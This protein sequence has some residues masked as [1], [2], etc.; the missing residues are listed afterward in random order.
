MFIKPIDFSKYS[1]IKIGPVVNVLMIEKGDEFPADRFLV[2]GANNLLISPTPPPLMMLSKDFDYCLIDGDTLEIG[3]ATPTGKILSFA[4]KHDLAGFEF[5]AKLPGTLGGML[6]MNAGVKEYEIFNILESIE[7]DGEWIPAQEIEHGYRFARLP[8][9]ATAARFPLRKGYDETLR[10]E[11]LK[12]R[13]NQ[14][15]EPSAG[16]AFKNPPGDYA[17]RLIEAVGLKGHRLGNMAWSEIHANF[18]VNMGGGTY[19]E[20]IALIELAKERVWEKFDTTLHEE[21][22]IVSESL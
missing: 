15:K 2:G 7:I 8:G 12:L 20:A 3:A 13:N 11:L 21:V 16:S 9:I 19:E 18:L 14:P 4:K 10:K 17:G 1:S 22:K 5:V 6:A